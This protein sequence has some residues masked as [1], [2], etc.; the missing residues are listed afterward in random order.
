MEYMAL[1]YSFFWILFIEIVYLLISSV[2]LMSFNIF[3]FLYW[4]PK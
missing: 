4:P 1:S 2:N 3:I